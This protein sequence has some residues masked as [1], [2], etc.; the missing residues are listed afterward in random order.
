MR[1]TYIGRYRNATPGQSQLVVPTTGTVGLNGREFFR[2]AG[3]LSFLH[4]PEGDGG[5]P[6]DAPASAADLHI[7]FVD[8]LEGE[9][10]GFVDHQVNKD[11]A[12]EAARAPDEENLRLKIGVTRAVVYQVRRREGN[13][14]VHEPVDRRRHGQGFG[15]DLQREDLAGDDPGQQPSASGQTQFIVPEKGYK[16]WK[17]LDLRVD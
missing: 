15:T 6:A 3:S 16:L 4:L 11:D 17:Y 13:N 1:R 7:E 10:L 12:D 2:S 8:L 5:C 9:A 14:P